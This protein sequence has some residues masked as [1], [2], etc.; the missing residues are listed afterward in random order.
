MEGGLGEFY[1]ELPWV[2]LTGK[3]EKGLWVFLGG[4]GRSRRAQSAP[5]TQGPPRIW[6]GKGDGYLEEPDLEDGLGV[7][8]VIA[9]QVGVEPG[10]GGAEIR[11]PGGWGGLGG[12]GPTPGVPEPRRAPPK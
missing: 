10:A 3:G 5:K 7:G 1:L 12:S 9:L 8:E 2:E 4:T 6:G 11:D